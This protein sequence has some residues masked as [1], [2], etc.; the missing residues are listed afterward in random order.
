MRRS[1]REL[2]RLEDAVVAQDLRQ[3]EPR[4]LPCGHE[5]PTTPPGRLPQPIAECSECRE[6]RE[7]NRPKPIEKTVV[8]HPAEI[9]RLTP[10]QYALVERYYEL[11]PEKADIAGTRE[12]EAILRQMDAAREDSLEYD[13]RKRG[14]RSR[15]CTGR[16]QDGV[17][18]EFHEVA[19]L[20]LVQVGG[21]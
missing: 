17:W 20:G 8:D 6:Q 3:Q 15:F 14:R 9:D 11:H 21:D 5:A 7:G 16:I 10:R 4:I 12:E 19:G 2:R 18:I 13:Q 1:E